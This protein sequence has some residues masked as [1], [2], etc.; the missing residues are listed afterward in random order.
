M[1]TTIDSL[2]I[3]IETSAGK[4][5]VNIDQLA[6]ALERLKIGSGN[7]VEKLERLNKSLNKLGTTK[8]GQMM[9]RVSSST[10]RATDSTKKFG[11]ALSSLDLFSKIQNLQELVS[12]INFVTDAM[13]ATLSQAMEWD[14][15]QFRFG[16]AFGE[17]AEE[18]YNW[19]L[20]I[21]EAL[22]INVQEFMQ[23]SSLYGSLLSGFGMAQEKV[24]TISVGLTELSYDIWAA[25]NDRFKSLESA[26]EAVRSAI[27]GEIEPIR[28][29][30]IAL[31]EA[32][33]QEYIDSTE[34]AGLSIEKLTEAQKAEVRYAA[35][36]NA[37]MNQGI[38]GTYAREMNTAEG[39]VR[40]LSQSFKTLVQALGGL[41]IPVLMKV[42]PYVTAFVEILTAAIRAVAGF[43]GIK[44]Q[45]IDWSASAKGVG[46]LATGAE[47]AS[48]GLG[49]AAKA[50]KKLK[51]YTLGF[52][53]LNVIKPDSGSS[54]SGGAGGVGGGGGFGDGLDLETLWDESLLAQASKRVDEIKDKIYGFFEKYK[55]WI[56]IAS[57]LTTAF[58]T[59]KAWKKLDDVFDI[60][61]KF[62]A[63]PKMFHES[64]FGNFT[65]G[66]KLL[67][68]SH[69]TFKEFLAGITG[70]M[71][72]QNFM[73]SAAD[74]VLRLGG[75]IKTALTKLPSFIVN[76]VKAIP[77]W[78]WV[79]AAIAAIIGIAIA[80]YDFTDIGYKIGHALG[81][82]LKKIGEWL[83]AATDWIVSVGKSILK[84]INSS[85]EWVKEE[86]DIKN[87]FELIVVMFNPVAWITK[88]VP[89]MIEIGKEVLPG[90]WKGIKDG[91]NNFWSNI[92]EF[93]DGFIQGFK[94]G[95]GINSPS[96]VF[97]EIGTYVVEG[98]L[99]GITQK[100]EAVKSWFKT[101][102]APKFT[103]AYWDSKFSTIKTSVAGRLEDAKKAIADKWSSVKSWYNANVAPKFTTAYWSNL[104]D[105]IRSGLKKKLDEAWSAVKNF[106]SVSEWSKKVKDAMNAV[107]NNFKMPSLPKIK[108]SITWDT[109]V[110]GLKKKVLDA[111]G[112]S[113]WPSLKWSTYATGGFPMPG[114][115]FVARENG[116]E[117]VGRIGN[118]SAVANN[119][120]IVAAVAQGVY[121]AV[122]SAMSESNGGS[123]QNINVYLDGKQ[124]Y[125][126]V[127]KTEAS[128]GVNIMGNQLGYLY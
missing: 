118:R 2:E 38:V 90:L 46:G 25:Y 42:I 89:K 29:A 52:D 27:T 4:S 95:L 70:G 41:F 71:K 97:A 63:F 80:D 73:A 8:I 76:A 15:I 16:R 20:K 111:L 47:D 55:V 50:A 57:A 54:G 87:V 107:K 124:L 96:R 11:G 72:T 74:L 33:L 7:A 86:F 117:M 121:S 116:P 53:E 43:F 66:L 110:T 36:V 10:D 104:F 85:W 12:A 3:R 65:S 59:N 51:D 81:S 64:W 48:K 91:W 77:G 56:G 24:T 92:E 127:R 115:Y 21:N 114:E 126:S 88:I 34:L 17:D 120:Q 82:A 106:F 35:M 109:N 60:S 101:A 67:K 13:A 37:A 18:T 122:V 28:N 49:K 102:V 108:L 19:I 103:M 62:K 113:G 78:G 100:W 22:G 23:Y 61:K 79:I 119:D 105:S 26:S 6:D 31:T 69:I 125:A 99:N 14:G 68:N 93:I 83:G 40:S 44:L 84:G 9:K 39:A 94:D 112:L 58:L 32:S 123:N 5:A 1:S 128:Q 45:P 75:A 30:G 98:F